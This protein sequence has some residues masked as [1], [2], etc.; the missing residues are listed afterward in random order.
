MSAVAMDRNLLVD[1]PAAARPAEA[2]CSFEA[3]TSPMPG[4]VAAH[5][6]HVSRAA[7]HAWNLEP[8][9]QTFIVAIKDRLHRRPEERSP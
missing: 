8:A 5:V 6:S 7:Y 3:M 9:F 1:R 2:L 4:V